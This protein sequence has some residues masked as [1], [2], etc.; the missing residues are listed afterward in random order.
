MLYSAFWNSIRA[1]LAALLGAVEQASLYIPSLLLVVCP[2]RSLS[3]HEQSALSLEVTTNLDVGSLGR[4]VGQVGVWVCSL[5]G[6]EE[7]LGQ[8]LETVLAREVVPRRERVRRPL[9]G[10]PACRVTFGVERH[11]DG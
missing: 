6:A 7:Q 2:D 5:E 3:P 10:K 8:Q 1:S 9:S 11:A 4:M